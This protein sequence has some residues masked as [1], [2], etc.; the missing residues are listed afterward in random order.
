MKNY[1]RH[2]DRQAL[3]AALLSEIT[4]ILR[5]FEELKIADIC[6]KFR[7]TL[8]GGSAVSP[9]ATDALTFPI[10]IYEKCADR[11]GTLGKEEAAGVVRRVLQRP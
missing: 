8:K 11:V 6:G 4:T 2:L 9:V 10:R 5:L 3:A 7:E 1:K